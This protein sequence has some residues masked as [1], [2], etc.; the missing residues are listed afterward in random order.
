MCAALIG[1]MDRGRKDDTDTQGKGKFQIEVNSEFAYDKK[2]ADG[3]TKK[4]T[5]GELATVLSYGIIDNLDIILGLPY[6]WTKTKEDGEITSDVD[7]ISDISLEAKW[8]F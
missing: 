4:E 6:Q 5:D 2:T 3:V 8:R 7:G 1:G